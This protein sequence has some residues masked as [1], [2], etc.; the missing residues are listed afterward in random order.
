[1]FWT[2]N[3]GD[4]GHYS[5]EASSVTWETSHLLTPVSIRI[6]D[7]ILD[8]KRRIFW[9]KY[10]QK[11]HL[12]DVFCKTSP[13]EFSAQ[14]PIQ[15]PEQLLGSRG[16]ARERP[17]VPVTLSGEGTLYHSCSSEPL[18]F[19]FFFIQGSQRDLN[20]SLIKPH[21]NPGE[22]VNVVLLIL[23]DRLG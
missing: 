2:D 5:W 6:A 19:I 10:R 22:D 7:K 8:W 20:T 14:G 16:A 13:D 3:R 4:T 1:M 15:P 12:R 17:Y 21:H 9:E 18:H 11:F 23:S